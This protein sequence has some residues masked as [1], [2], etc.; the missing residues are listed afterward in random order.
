MAGKFAAF[1]V[2]ASPSRK[3]SGVS[4]RVGAAAPYAGDNTKPKIKTIERKIEIFC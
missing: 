2:T 3:I 1:T 4:V